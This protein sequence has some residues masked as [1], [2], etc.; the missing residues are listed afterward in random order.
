M[1][2]SEAVRRRA[3]ERL[4]FD[5]PY[6]AGGVTRDSSG[7]WHLPAPD[8]FQGCAKILDKRKR[9]V[10]AIA[11][12]WQLEL[13]EALEA[14]RAQGLPMRV[15]ILKARKLGFSTWIA[16]KFLQR[17]TQLPYQSAVIVA[18]DVDTAGDILDMAK[19]AWEQLPE[20]EELGLGFPIK[21]ALI[22]VTE[23]NNSRKHML[24]G[25][26]SAHARRRG[27]SA[28]SV[29]TIDTAGSPAAGRGKTP[30]LVHLSEV[31]FWDSAQAQ[32]KL[33]AMLEALPY[34]EETMC[35][36]ESTANGLNHFHD[37]W[38]RARE[39]AKDPE[40]GEVYTP[41]FV[42]WWRDMGCSRQFATDEGRARFVETIGDVAAYG[43]VAEEEPML[44]ELYECTAEQLLWRRMKV[45]EH[46]SVQ[47]FNQ[48]NPHSDEVAF[49]GSG[50]PVFGGI[51]IAK[52]IKATR[53]APEPVS[54]TLRVAEWEDKRSRSGIVHVPKTTVWVPGG[55]KN[56]DEHELFVWEHPRLAAN[57]PQE[58]DGRPTTPFE[59]RDGAY[60]V[61]SDIAGGEANTLSEGDFHV[62]KVFDWHTRLEVATHA[63]R[64]DPHLLPLWILQIAL[65]FNEA[66][67]A[68]ESNNMGVGVVDVL[69]REY[70]Y[71]RMYKRE[72]V[73]VVED[74][75][76]IRAGWETNLA[77]KPAMEVTFGSLL[78]SAPVDSTGKPLPGGLRDQQTA[79]ELTTYVRT[80]K[81]KHEAQPGQYDDR[82]MTAMIAQQVM[83]MKRPP[84]IGGKRIEQ[85]EPKDPITGY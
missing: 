77:T 43:E 73:G 9:L 76:Q 46:N 21:P 69:Q 82:L 1:A 40:T 12:P 48:E 14:Q 45:Q 65:Y 6:W 44:Q 78:D 30:N 50:R 19:L 56:A 7:R 3:E 84:K 8:E 53:E 27:A 52:A 16:L 24:F 47:S 59:R 34:V 72:L 13:D 33:L 22:G 61:A 62:V 58:I 39:G 63:S 25:E 26:P 37:R 10:P 64:M 79:R 54:G 60:F 32:R 18:Q 71:R 68:V 20:E 11:R 67:V 66:R 70:R 36:I 35:A 57:A 51:L 49:I 28:R 23:S 5:T 2:L 81:G 4:K 41:I 38:V 83:A 75:E 15:I 80:D 55:R 42:G 31:A 74:R 85:F 29:F 17:V